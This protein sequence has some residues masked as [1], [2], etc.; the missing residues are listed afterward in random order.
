MNVRETARY[1]RL[2][3]KKVYTLASE[4]RLPAT[5]ATG[6]WLFPRELIDQWLIESSH[7]GVFTDRIAV[8]G[9]SDP[10]MRLAAEQVTAA[11]GDRAL[12]C[13]TGT[14]TRPGLW[15]LARRRAD[16]C[17]IHWGPLDESHHRHAALLRHHPQ[18]REWVL[19]R[20]F[21]REQGVLVQAGKE[22]DAAAALRTPW[23]WVMRQDGSGSDRF[24]RDAIADEGI[25]VAELRS[26]SVYIALSEAEAAERVATGDADAAPGSRA[27]AATHGLGFIPLGWEA[28]DLV[29][30]RGVYFRVLFRHLLDA[31]L[32]PA[33][34]DRAAHLGGYDFRDCGKLIWAA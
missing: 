19:V 30:S 21:A 5:K 3:E 13:Y 9:S 29:L 27:A 24:L 22:R 18:H 31:L 17:G 14:G 10:L 28:V 25:E 33:C 2:N 20:A 23:R 16:V 32:G 26:R 1:L 4:G 15:Q 7:G 34:Q 12:V 8:V 6:K 11:S